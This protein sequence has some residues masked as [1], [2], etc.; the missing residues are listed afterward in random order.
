M[1]SF[2]W[3]EGVKNDLLLNTYLQARILKRGCVGKV[4][5]SPIGV[6]HAKGQLHILG[7]QLREAAGHAYIVSEKI[8]TTPSEHNDTI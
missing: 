8:R 6:E 3:Q 2:A 7:P 4:K 5:L 1:L